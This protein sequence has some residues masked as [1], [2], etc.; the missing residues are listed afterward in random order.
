MAIVEMKRVTVVGMRRDR[1]A[2]LAA[3]ARAGVIDVEDLSDA[4][5]T[6]NAGAGAVTAAATASAGAGAATDAAEDATSPTVPETGDPGQAEQARAHE[7]AQRLESLIALSAQ[8]AP[9]AK[10]RGL[11]SRRRVSPT[12]VASAAA[13]REEIL[14]DAMELQQ[15]RAAIAADR[16]QIARLEATASLLEPWAGVPLRLD[17]DGTRRTRVWPGSIPAGPRFDE[18]MTQIAAAGPRVHVEVLSQQDGLARLAVV[19]LHEDENAVRP[20]LKTGGLAP[21]PVQ[22]ERGTPDEVLARLAAERQALRD[23]IARLEQ[24]ARE[25]AARRPDFEILYDLTLADIARLDSAARLRHTRSTFE[26]AGW[27]PA[28]LADETLRGL[29][30]TYTVA[31]SVRAPR[32][33]EDVPTLMENIPLVRPYEAIT[34]MFSTPARGEI[35][36]NPLVAPF[37]AILFGLMVNDAGYGLVLTLACALMIWKFKV[38][39]ATRGMMMLFFQGGIAATVAGV[40]FGGFFGDIVSVLSRDRIHFPTLWFSPLED[41]V[42]MMAVSLGLGVVHV[43][44]GMGAKAYMLIRDKKPLDALF[45]VG[46]WYLA[47]IGAGLMAVGGVIGRVG[48]W[49]M[50]VGM[51]MV[52]LFSARQSRGLGK[53]IFKGLYNLYG[54][55]GYLSDILSY[56]RILA[57]GLAGGVIAMV[58]NKIGAIAGFGIVG[59]PLFILVA[60]VGHGLNIALSLLGAYVHTSR[61][62]YVEFFSKFFEGGGRPWNPLRDPSRYTEIAAPE[63][64]ESGGES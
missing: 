22:G 52:V 48:T 2:L 26:L 20:L 46:S 31:V 44:T 16:G 60:L 63:T 50:V 24:R 33:D 42:M 38:K 43:F 45:D 19:A 62:Q 51:A 8:I 57:L 40:L 10:K 3:L 41:P 53:R 59:L 23:G 28:T 35:D 5:A 21:I 9:E 37:F 55:T 27:I 17:E 13:R 7:T 39:G 47:L 34:T 36:P 6:A 29:R 61:L 58:F 25:L 1:D 54:I 30:D 18:F 14:A 4:A 56:S 32:D 15:V 12:Q 64:P 11:A 49:M